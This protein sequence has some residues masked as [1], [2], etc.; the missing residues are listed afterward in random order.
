MQLG[1]YVIGFLVAIVGCVA[2]F[3]GLPALRLTNSP[4][5]LATVA[6]GLLLVMLGTWQDYPG[7]APAVPATPEAA[8]QAR[9][10]AAL[11]AREASLT[12]WVVNKPG[13]ARDTI[14]AEWTVARG[15]TTIGVWYTVHQVLQAVH[16][17]GLANGGKVW[18]KVRLPAK[19][20]YGNASTVPGLNLLFEPETL[21]RINWREVNP[22]RLG[23][24]ATTVSIH[25]RLDPE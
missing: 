4:R 12:T 24:L 16:E 18:I 7:S 2:A 9:V 21:G 1:L 17:S 19:D 22:A 20:D 8:L 3:R 13:V 6:A 11:A 25:P 15:F 14:E 5:A 23:R 10:H